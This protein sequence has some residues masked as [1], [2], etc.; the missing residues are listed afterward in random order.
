MENGGV[1]LN[2]DPG[3]VAGLLGSGILLGAGYILFGISALR[4]K[5]FPRIPLWLLILGAPLFGMGVLFPLRTLGLVLFCA[6]TI[7]LALELRKD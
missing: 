7:W 2:G 3:I 4:S 6:G 1:L 5:I